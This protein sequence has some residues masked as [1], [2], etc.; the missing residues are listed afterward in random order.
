MRLLPTQSSQLAGLA[1]NQETEELYAQFQNGVFYKYE[2]VPEKVFV[3]VMLAES[4][5]SAFTEKVKNGGF[6]FEKVEDVE[7]LDFHV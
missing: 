4:Q 5:G 6:P 3:D 2:G 7:E 1:Y